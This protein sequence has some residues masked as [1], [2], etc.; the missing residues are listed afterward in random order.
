VHFPDVR[1]EF[2]E[3]D[4]RW[5]HVDVE[6]TTM[7][8]RGAHGANAARSGF[9]CYRGSS[10]RV[11]GRGGGGGRGSAHRGGLAEEFLE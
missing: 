10:S 11:G 1:I 4:G 9:S 5:D 2:R 6:V 3:A 8:Y 7:H